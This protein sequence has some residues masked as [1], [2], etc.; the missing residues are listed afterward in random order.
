MRPELSGKLRSNNNVFSW[1][2]NAGSNGE[3]WQSVPVELLDKLFDIC[4][5]LLH[6]TSANVCIN[7]G[8]RE[9][10]CFCRQHVIKR[11]Y[12]MVNINPNTACITNACCLIFVFNCCTAHQNHIALLL[13]F[14]SGINTP[15]KTTFVGKP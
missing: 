8:Q 11:S 13:C 6:S 15:A 12:Q 1:L 10:K 3:R 14:F 7:S 2:L 9:V 4:N 5:S